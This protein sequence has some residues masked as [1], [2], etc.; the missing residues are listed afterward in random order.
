MKFGVVGVQGDVEEHEAAAD[1]AGDALGVDVDTVRVRESGVVPDCDVVALPGGE[2][3]TISSLVHREDIDVELRDH[4]QGGG[5]VLATCAGLILASSDAG[6]DRVET[7]GL[8]DVDVERNAFG[9]QRESFEAEVD[10]RGF[11]SPFPG[12]FIR[13]PAV[14]RVGD[15]KV[16]AEHRGDVVAVEGGAADNVV[17]TSFHPELTDDHRLHE[18]VFE[19]AR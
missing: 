14:T 1:A 10:I 15:A 19:D 7:L 4:V 11:D 8:L 6:D 12:V 16:L 5:P 18:K 2:S 9:R 13:A 3:T 17:G